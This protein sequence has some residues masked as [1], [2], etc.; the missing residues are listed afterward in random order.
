MLERAGF[1]TR[2]KADRFEASDREA[3]QGRDMQAVR[4]GLYVMWQ[5]EVENA[6]QICCGGLHM[7]DYCEERVS[8]GMKMRITSASAPATELISQ[9]P[10]LSRRWNPA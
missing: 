4:G 2:V 6:E 5:A 7:A 10:Q 3:W 9:A 1:A 8:A